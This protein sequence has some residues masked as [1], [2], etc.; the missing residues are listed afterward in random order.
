MWIPPGGAAGAVSIPPGEPVGAVKIPPEGPATD[1]PAPSPRGEEDHPPV[2]VAAAARRRDRESAAAVTS[3][4]GAILGSR[5]GGAILGSRR[6]AVLL[7][8]PPQLSEV[9]RRPSS[10]CE[11]HVRPSAGEA[12]RGREPEIVAQLE[13]GQQRGAGDGGRVVVSGGPRGDA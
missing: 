1:R 5:G 11:H 13:T 6:A 9:P 8:S 10:I 12:V 3:G 7:V 2:F 4:G